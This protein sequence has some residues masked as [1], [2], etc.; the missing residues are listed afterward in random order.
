[1][2]AALPIASVQLSEEQLAARDLLQQGHN[3]FLTG[4]AG[5]GKSTVT[6]GF[7]G[8][9]LRQVD[10]AATTG[11]AAINLRDQF[12]SKAGRTLNVSTVYRWAGI[13][14]GP[15]VG[16][17]NEDFFQWWRVQPF[18]TPKLIRRIQ[19]AEVLV[20]DEISMLPGRL[21]D[22]LDYHC[23]MLRQSKDPFGGIQVVAVGDFLQLPP[24]DKEGRGYDW[25]FQSKAWKEADFKPAVLTHVHRQADPEFADLLN[26]FRMGEISKPSGRVLATRVSVFPDAK[27][28]RLMT[29]NRAVDKWNQSQLEQLP[30]ETVTLTAMVIGPDSQRDWMIKNMVTP[31]Y[32]H[33]R[34][35]ARVMVTANLKDDTGELIFCN[36]TMAVVTGING[37]KVGVLSDDG[38]EAI[39]SKHMWQFD[40]QDSESAKFFQVPLRLAWA[41]TIHKSQGLTLPSAYIDIRSAREPGQAYVA[42]SRIKSLDGLHLREAPTGLFVSEA[43][44]AFHRK[45]ATQSIIA[46]Y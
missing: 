40:A 30:G 29:H 25:A 31:L 4:S 3:V 8:S 16:Q 38:V 37:E 15:K 45:A 17:T 43:A 21:L 12:A 42:I 39:L 19:W 34:V 9:S 20:I 35:G 18:A 10:V 32:L 36:G 1:M 22:Y 24:V 28:P 26:D 46:P 23:K 2:T 33:L 5:T 44:I 7:I 14:L 6:T 13:G 27:I 41:S 11:I